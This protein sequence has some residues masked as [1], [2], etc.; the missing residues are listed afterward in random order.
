MSILARDG[1]SRAE[2]GAVARAATLSWDVVGRVARALEGF[3]SGSE[4]GVV[5]G[6]H[7]S[8]DLSGWRS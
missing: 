4:V 3:S 6:H 8:L 1:A 7:C 2:L 5:L